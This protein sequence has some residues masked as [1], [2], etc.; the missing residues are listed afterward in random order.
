MNR[1]SLE[2]KDRLCL[3]CGLMFNYGNKSLFK[4]SSKLNFKR[5]PYCKSKR[6]IDIHKAEEIAP[7]LFRLYKTRVSIAG[8]TVDIDNE[9]G[10]YNIKIL[11]NSHSKEISAVFASHGDKMKYFSF[12][13]LTNSDRVEGDDRYVLEANFSFESDFH[14][15]GTHFASFE[16]ELKHAE[17]IVE[18][19][20]LC[21]FIDNKIIES[22]E[23]RQ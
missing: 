22:I 19:E 23:W 17:M 13:P 20:S 1:L 10:K 4:R 14:K 5:C 21:W 9:S 3:E 15:N 16:Y 12:H 7:M 6:N 18:F 2:Y 8:Y 11:T